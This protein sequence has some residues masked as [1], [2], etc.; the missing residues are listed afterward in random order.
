[1]VFIDFSGKKK[2]QLQLTCEKIELD[3]LRDDF[4]VPNPAAAS[5]R[6]HI[7]ARLYAITP[8]GKFDTG[9]LKNV[10]INM[11]LHGF[12]Y[13]ISENIK[14]HFKILEKPEILEE[15]ALPYRLYQSDAIQTA[16]EAGNG[17]VVVGTGGG[18][19]LL[20]AGLI[21]NLRK[22]LGKPDAKVL[23]TVPTLQLVE[24][25]TSDF[26]EYGLTDVTK[27]SGKNKIDRSANII[28]AGTQY[29]VGKNTDL[30]ILDDI[31]IL[32][33]DEVHCFGR[34]NKLNKIFKFLKT[35][36]RFGLTGTLPESKIDEWNIIGKIGPVI[37]EK[38]TDSLVKDDFVA[39]FNICI[40]NIDHKGIKFSFR[41]DEPTSK[42][43]NEIDYLMTNQNRN[44]I[45]AKLALKISKNTIIMVDRIIH[46]ESILKTL[47]ATGDIR[48]IVF[49][50]GSTDIDDRELIRDMMDKQ[51]NVI[52][53]AISKI[54]STGL[55]I[56]NLHCIIFANAGKAKTKI[57]QSIGRSIRKHPTKKEALIFD[58]SD[59]TYYGFEHKEKRKKL[60]DREKYP[61]VEK[62]I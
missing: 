25:T 19:T 48:P 23:I 56:P 57:I 33:A 40:L 14:N 11:D 4:S 27:W 41:P 62:Y 16:I 10:Q 58:V 20:A 1:M 47:K 50:Q 26:I 59:N 52:V 9:L 22:L 12:P 36:Y 53:I 15:L 6:K 29:L 17:I 44:G 49:I 51:S 21:K 35:S 42:Y 60:Y 30:S 7:P 31:D 46:G 8:T 39:P 13:E 18:K 54:F 38:K 43:N 55:N 5:K 3:I 61:W 24:Q 34:N 37:Y 28:V 45:I 32:I 2:D